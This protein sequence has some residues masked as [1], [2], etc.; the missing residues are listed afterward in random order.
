M[1]QRS[2]PNSQYLVTPFKETGHLTNEQKYFNTKI[3][4]YRQIIE[5]AIGLLK[6]R[7]RTLNCLNHTD[8][9]MYINTSCVSHNNMFK[10]KEVKFEIDVLDKNSNSND[11]NQKQSATRKGFTSHSTSARIVV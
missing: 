10:K 1:N 4:K 7:F 2:I 9:V 8:V 3:S 5:R 11:Q 6:G